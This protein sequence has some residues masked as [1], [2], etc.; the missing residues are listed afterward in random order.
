MKG[1]GWG[2]R[3]WEGML[4][5]FKREHGV[6]VRISVLS[7]LVSIWFSERVVYWALCSQSLRSCLVGSPRTRIGDVA[8]L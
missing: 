3:G 2:R 4:M 6:G 1:L 5:V 7:V 8:H